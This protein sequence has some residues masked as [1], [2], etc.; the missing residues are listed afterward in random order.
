MHIQW[1]SKNYLFFLLYPHIRVFG[2]INKN[3][4]PAKSVICSLTNYN[5]FLLFNS[6]FNIDLIKAAAR[7]TL[8]KYFEYI[9]TDIISFYEIK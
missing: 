6:K 5:N 9:H 2:S 1:L 4:Y 7:K 3:Y 8:F